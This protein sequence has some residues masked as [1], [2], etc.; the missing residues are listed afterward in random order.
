MKKSGSIKRPKHPGKPP[1]TPPPP[2]PPSLPNYMKSTTSSDARKESKP[3]LGSSSGKKA[4]KAVA[5]TLTKNP[6]FKPAVV[7]KRGAVVICENGDAKRAT[8]SSTLKDCKLP[9]YLSLSPGGTESVGT[10][11]IKVC[12]YTYCSLNGHHHAPL[13]PLKCFLSARRRAIKTQR[14]VKLGCSSP[15]RGRAVGDDDDL[16]SSSDSRVIEEQSND[17]FVEVYAAGGGGVDETASE[18]QEE[19]VCDDFDGEDQEVSFEEERDEEC[20]SESSPNDHFYERDSDGSDME[21]ETGYCSPLQL[22]YSY[23]CSPQAA[24]EPDP[25]I[26]KDEFIV[27]SDGKDSCCDENLVDEVSQESF[28]EEG[29]SSDAFPSSDDGSYDDDLQ[30]LSSFE[31]SAP[32][33]GLVEEAE[34]AGDE[35]NSVEPECKTP[36]TDGNLDHEASSEISDHECLPNE[37]A[38]AVSRDES[39]EAERRVLSKA[40]GENGAETE[41]EGV[42]LLQ[43]TAKS[44]KLVQDGDELGDFNPRAPNFL[45]LEADPEAQK[46]DLKHQDLD[47][48]KNAEEWMVDYALRQVVTKLGP[49]RKRKVSLLVE[50]FEKVMPASKWDLQLRHGSEFDQARPIQACR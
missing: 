1:P 11:V 2:P 31:T 47:E 37:E 5:R 38:V 29:F 34:G 9:A 21:R 40:N 3:K 46:V 19:R 10:S 27:S 25:E 8:C 17:F 7:R 18:D 12:P 6:S 15:R 35:E 26:M 41:T 33:Q 4:T 13:P 39:A 24:G 48:R 42:A 32:L 36:R 20:L 22:D 49:A 23:E 14:I 43:F 50:A 16:R 30:S 28:D 45:P 44:K